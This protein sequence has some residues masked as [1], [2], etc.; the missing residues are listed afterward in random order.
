M[1]VCIGGP[2][3]AGKSTLMARLEGSLPNASTIHAVTTRAR[4]P[5]SSDQKPVVSRTKFDQL[6]DDGRFC[7]VNSFFGHYYGTPADL[8]EEAL[9]APSDIFLLDFPMA[10][11]DLLSS[12]SGHRSLII[13]SATRKLISTRLARSR[14]TERIADAM[15][16][17]DRHLELQRSGQL[18]LLDFPVCRLDA[19]KRPDE[20]EALALEALLA[21][22]APLE[23]SSPRSEPD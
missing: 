20:L 15:A 14:R 18:G 1:L 17:V 11:L 9:T 6:D 13:L 8:V 12:W 23:S 22:G 3:A 7:M 16:D 5:D 4:R 2:T 19:A 10:R 21:E